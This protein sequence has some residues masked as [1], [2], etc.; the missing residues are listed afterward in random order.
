MTQLC[1]LQACAF[2]D[3]G[4]SKLSRTN[5]LCLASTSIL[6]GVY[7]ELLANLINAAASALAFRSGLGQVV[8]SHR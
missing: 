7:R 8:N 1:T 5:I 4:R 6:T 2:L 3:T